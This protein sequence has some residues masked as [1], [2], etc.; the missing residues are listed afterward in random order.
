[1][2]WVHTPVHDRTINQL[3]IKLLDERREGRLR[4]LS[5]PGPSMTD[6]SD[7]LAEA[8]FPIHIPHHHPISPISLTITHL[9][10]SLPVIPGLTGNLSH[11]YP[12][13]PNSPTIVP[14]PAKLPHI[15]TRLVG[16][17]GLPRC[18]TGRY[19]PLAH[20]NHHRSAQNGTSRAPVW[21]SKRPADF[22]TRFRSVEMTRSRA[23]SISV[24]D[25]AQ[26][27]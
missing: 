27:K 12:P 11:G 16:L 2:K 21:R 23:R 10:Q 15:G 24:Q 13:S 22:S 14:A 7:S 20:R 17:A 6:A 4:G 1:M 25:T 26:S 8:P 19:R 3:I 5:G 9:P 18:T